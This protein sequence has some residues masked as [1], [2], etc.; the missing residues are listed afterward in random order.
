MKITHIA[1]GGCI[2]APDVPYGLT[3]DT[4]GH[5]AYILGAAQAQAERRDISAVELVTRAFDV[6]ELGEVYGRA[7]QRVGPKF[8]IRRLR[9]AN[10]GYL[11][12]E[13]LAAELPALEAA[14]LESLRDARQRPDL[15]HAHF[16]D[17]ALLARA[18]RAAFGIPF[19]YTPHSLGIDKSGCLGAGQ[20]DPVLAAR[21]E[22]ERAALD[23]ADAVIV[24]SRDEGE[25]QVAAYGVGLE[26]RVHRVSP[27]VTLAPRP[28]HAAARAFLAPHLDDPEKP[29]ILAIARPVS[30]KNLAALARAYAASPALQD[31]ANLV[32]LAGQHRAREEEGARVLRDLTRALSAP[33]LAGRAALPPAHD[34]AEV[35]ALYAFAARTRGVF[36]NPA[37]HEPFGLTVLEAAANGLPV[38]ATRNGGPADIV[39]TLGHGRCVDP[40]CETGIGEAILGL[41]TDAAEWDRAARAGRGNIWRYDWTAWA[42]E[43]QK[44]YREASARPAPAVP[45]APCLLVSDIDGT[46]TGCTEGLRALMGWQRAARPRFAVATGRSIVEARRV[47]REWNVPP[48]EIFIASVGTEIYRRCGSGA[49]TLDTRYAA[50]LDEDWDRAATLRAMRAF[51]LPFQAEV[52]QRRW[53]LSGV[54]TGAEAERLARHLE[55]VGLAARVVASHDR[56][57]DV[58]PAQGGKGAAVAHVT[59]R[60][61]L[62]PSDVIVA[63]DSGN[64]LDMLERAGRAIVVGN[65]LP[66]LLDRLTSDNVYY[67][68]RPHA[69]GVLEGLGHFGLAAGQ[70]QPSLEAAQ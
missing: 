29:L 4:G 32:I 50:R 70:A 60:L 26:R 69:G 51:G 27:G 19:V 59:E 11:S 22:Q 30:R 6:P 54:G 28:D 9:T 38:V 25:R 42:R 52:E 58:I 47:L 18:A 24:S 43:A 49:F 62:A 46:L 68:E 7:H 31:K 20:G 21:I 13:A 64:D 15:I 3:E 10:T 23:E 37:L 5:I 63:G 57:I 35:K 56:L 33:G 41:L 2:T 39:A 45:A 16:A 48:P 66:E 44:I 17:A 8:T 12:K 61:G 65:A 34:S 14:F 36:V 67:A 55:A 1:L 40:A 53:K